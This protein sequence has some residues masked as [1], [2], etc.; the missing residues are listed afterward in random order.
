LCPQSQIKNQKS[1]IVTTTS[2]ELTCFLLYKLAAMR[3]QIEPKLAKWP[4]YLGDALMLGAA[5]GIYH[6]S[7]LPMGHWELLLA[8]LCIAGGAVLGVAPFLTEYRAWT[9]LSQT[10]SLQSAAAQIGN[11]ESLAA[12]I[13]GATDQWNSVHERA[14]Q[15]AEHSRKLAERM[16]AEVKAFTEFLERANDA[17]KT[18][19]RL[20]VEKLKRVETEWLQVLVRVLDH[21]YAL[22]QGALRSG[23]PRL[24][25]E[26]SRFQNACCDVARRVGLAPFSAA[27]SEPLDLSRHEVLDGGGKPPAEGLVSDTVAAGYTFQGH[28]I[29]PALVRLQ[30]NGHSEASQEAGST[31]VADSPPPAAVADAPCE[32]PPE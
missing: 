29:R 27:P 3:D 30:A 32:P 8:A 5:F 6:Q 12:Q 17:E 22:H 11:L 21:I 10:E 2:L 26:L 13:A 7:A 23:Q 28:I 4:F 1:K 16:G 24:I 14:E 20:E 19:L 31:G 15:T 9:K 25:E 18:N